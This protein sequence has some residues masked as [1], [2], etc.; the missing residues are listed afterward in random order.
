LY[1]WTPSLFVQSREFQMEESLCDLEERTSNKNQ[2]E[3]LP[4][5]V[6]TLY[7]VGVPLLRPLCERK[8]KQ[9]PPQ[10]FLCHAWNN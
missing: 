9:L 4:I 6:H 5:T 7:I 2:L 1:L 3:A 10:G 8:W